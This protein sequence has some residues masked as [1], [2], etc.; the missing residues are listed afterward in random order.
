MLFRSL[1]GLQ[2]N[3]QATTASITDLGNRVSYVEGEVKSVVSEVGDTQAQLQAVQSAQKQVEADTRPALA[4]ETITTASG[5]TTCSSVATASY[6]GS[7]ITLADGD[8]FLGFTVSLQANKVV[9]TKGAMI[10][11]YIP[12]VSVP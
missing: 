6:Q 12:E 3:Q 10:Y 4:V 5:C 1:E 11:T 7:Q 8:T 2:K 9:L